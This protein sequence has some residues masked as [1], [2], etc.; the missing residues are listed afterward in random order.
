MEHPLPQYNEQFIADLQQRAQTLAEQLQNGNYTQAAEI[1][2][3]LIDARDQHLF[4]AVGKLTRA[5]HD[6]IIKPAP[7]LDTGKGADGEQQADQQAESAQISGRLH[8][9]MEMMHNAADETL[10]KVETVAP[11]AKRLGEEARE[12]REQ[13]QQHY[14]PGEL[15]ADVSGEIFA[16]MDEFLGRAHQSGEKINS[17]LQE[18]ILEQSYQDL[19]GQVLMQVTGLV[20]NIEKDLVEVMQIAAQTKTAAGILTTANKCKTKISHKDTVSGQDDV[21]DLLSSLGF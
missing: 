6:G 8:S 17:D 14:K 15:G 19:T 1:V 11:L 18:V 12:L 10:D 16:R 9:V 21:D 4:T 7:D 20:T 2:Q 5:L 3:G 13:L